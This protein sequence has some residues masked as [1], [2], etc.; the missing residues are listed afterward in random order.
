MSHSLQPHGLWPTRL[1]CPWD[2]RGKNTGVGCHFLLQ[3]IFPIQGLNSRLLHWQADSL[4]PS[5]WGS[6]AY[7]S[8][9]KYL[10]DHQPTPGPVLSARVHEAEVVGFRQQEP[11]GRGL[12][13][14]RQVQG[15][16]D[17][18]GSKCHKDNRAKKRN[19]ACGLGDVVKPRDQGWPD[20]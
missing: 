1:L 12:A 6:S 3:G 10:R 17:A 16:M 20:L 2:F 15:Y 13:S 11:L 5:H 19:L 14:K 4:P 8:T 18:N 9:H 7:R